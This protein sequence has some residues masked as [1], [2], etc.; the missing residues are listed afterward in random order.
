[1][2]FIRNT[3][4]VQ[5]KNRRESIESDEWNSIVNQVSTQ[6]N[7]NSVAIE[8]ILDNL[9]VFVWEPLEDY[10]IGFEP[11]AIIIPDNS[12]GEGVTTPEELAK[13]F[14]LEGTGYPAEDWI[15]QIVE[16]KRGSRVLRIISTGYF[17]NINEND[18]TQLI[19]EVISR[20]VVIDGGDL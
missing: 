19:E 3:I 7:Y 13:Y 1:M 2:S 20:G 9:F 8:N 15:Y 10:D 6:G 17:Q 12:L 4:P 5:N 18:V 16:Y 14:N 11:Q